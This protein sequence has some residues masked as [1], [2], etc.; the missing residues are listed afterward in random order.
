MKIIRNFLNIIFAILFFSLTLC[1]ESVLAQLIPY[2]GKNNVKYDTFHWKIFK[3][4]HFDIYFYPEE[5]KHLQTVA[6]LAEDAYE[7]ISKDLQHD[8]PFRI[9][10]IYFLT[11]SEFEQVNYL[12]VT[13]GILGVS[14]PLY[15]RMA[16]ALDHNPEDLKHLITHELA[17]IF[18]FSILFGGLNISLI[19]SVPP[20]WIMEGYPE[21]VIGVWNSSDIQVVRDAILT[22]NIPYISAVNDIE[23][24]EGRDI[25]RA[26]Y[27]I[28]H[29]VFDFINDKYGRAGIRQL[30][31]SVKKATYLGQQDIFMQAFG[32]SEQKFNEEFAEWLREKFA[33]WKEKQTPYDKVFNLKIKKPFEQIL[34]AAP[35]PDGKYIAAFSVN[36]KDSEIDLVII[37]TEDGSVVK[38]ITKGYT[39]KFEYLTY[40]NYY[41]SGRNLTWSFDGKHIAFFARDGKRRSLYIANPLTGKI[42]KK[43]K[44]HLDL[45]GAP[46]F[47]PDGKYIAFS[48]LSG[49]ISDIYLI[50]LKNKNISNL[51]ND[52]YYDITPI[53]APDGKTILYSSR[54]SGNDQ[55]FE[56]N[57]NN[58]QLRIQYTFDN[59][60]SISP[61]YSPDMKII[62]FSAN[63][64][65]VNNIYA[66]N[67]ETNELL[68]LTDVIGG[69]YSPFIIIKGNEKHIFFTEFFKGKYHLVSIKSEEVINKTIV[70]PP[71]EYLAE[72]EQNKEYEIQIPISE[73]KIIKV[74]PENIKN[75]GFKAVLTSRPDVI[76]GYTGGTFAIASS[77]SVEDILGDQRFTFFIQR[78]YGFETYIFSYVDLG[79][80]LQY[81]S[82]F[83][84][85]NDFFYAPINELF[86]DVV[87]TK[88]TGGLF[89][90]IFPLNLWSRFE[91]GAG[92]FKISESFYY[93][94]AQYLY[95]DYLK[96]T[97]KE[98]Y[99]YNGY[100]VPLSVS[101]V[102]ETTRFAYWGP[103]SGHTYKLTLAISPKLSD[104]FLSRISFAA[105]ARKYFRTSNR[106]QL[107]FRVR[108]FN[109][110]G[111][112]ADYFYFGGGNDFRGVE[113]REI[114][115]N[116][117]AIINAEYR[118]PLLPS[119]L[120]YLPIIG[121]M[122]GKIFFDSG[123]A[124]I[125]GL[126][127]EMLSPREGLFLNDWFGSVGAGFTIFLGGLPFNFEFSK[128]H[129]YDKFIGGL[130]F[131]FSIGYSY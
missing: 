65:G 68:Q 106:T 72:L 50:N 61:F 125:K 85:L 15:N 79:H 130:H 108:L 43:Y 98:P 69:A 112:N 110:W 107:A 52:I 109:S 54:R 81:A 123:K 24:P 46:S 113:F 6:S 30:W 67:K 117:G 73:D 119:K 22:D 44:L 21:E 100:E 95:E 5:E 55:I 83:L 74:S 96:R 105:D 40:D 102:T 3:T 4:E 53:W 114:V 101:Y 58:P 28:G 66:L 16:F 38:N 51:T 31:F 91:L 49:G 92:F 17:H 120:T 9:P 99:L 36:K 82:T 78:I 19:K 71:K 47:S 124:K 45:A 8:V 77:L 131:D 88:Y 33:P 7:R 63:K 34:T 70:S 32:I 2:Y 80:R 56:I 90:S 118:F 97:G 57:V 86:Y 35:S 42:E 94:D 121:T 103:V 12:Q 11:S 29:A 39:T 127:K 122:R 89:Q 104:D 76:S 64:N 1:Q 37:D 87:E 27:T 59:Y 48:A 18:E 25:A 10:L 75:K 13:E 128:L 111:D 62:Y 20:L 60:N 115:G 126:P 84:R 23:Y 93:E 129:N 41:F 116:S 26:S 14:E